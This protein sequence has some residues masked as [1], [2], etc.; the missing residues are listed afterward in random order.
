MMTENKRTILTTG[1]SGFLGSEV[2]RQLL[3]S[4]CQVVNISHRSAP[5]EKVIS[6]SAD[7]TDIR[8]LEKVFQTYEISAIVHMAAAL[9]SHSNQNP[10]EAFR[11]NV[12]GSFNL[13]EMARQFNISRFVYASTYSLLGYR[14]PE[15][16][17]ADESLIPTP[18][19]FYGETKQFTEALGVNCGIKFG[20]HFSSGRMG[21]LVGPGQASASSAWRMD[22][23]NKLKTGGEIQV[24]FAP[25]TIMIFSLVED[26]AR[27]LVTLALAEK[28]R[29]AIYN[30]PHD[31]ITLEEMADFVTGLNPNIQFSFGRTLEHDMPTM[32]DASRFTSEFPQFKHIHLFEALRISQSNILE[33]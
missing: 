8:Q 17:L 11:L 6:E 33:E 5:L 23:F 4:G 30:L 10:D 32:I 28:N 24:K 31:S 18:D 19:N 15:F 1:G 14:E 16:G 26:T 27:A 13:M 20:F 3:D 12:L 22:I 2:C 29:H 25:Q 21:A 7:L 9:S